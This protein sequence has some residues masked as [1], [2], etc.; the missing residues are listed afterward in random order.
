[1]FSSDHVMCLCNHNLYA[2]VGTFRYMAPEALDA[3]VHLQDV[4]CFKQIDVYALA[5]VMWEIA[6]RCCVLTGKC[7]KLIC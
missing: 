7:V 3:R 4:Q 5:L 2:Q 1:M 6:S